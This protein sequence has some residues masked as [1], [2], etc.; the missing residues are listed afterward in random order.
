MKR[1]TFSVVAACLGLALVLALLG[2]GPA[3][4]QSATARIEGVVTDES[5]AAVPGA[6]V[7]ATSLGTNVAKAVKTD[8]KGGYV[9]TPL[10]V[11]AYQVV[12]QM[13]GF[14]RATANVTLTVSQV[15]RIDLKLPLGAVSE[16]IE[17]TGATPIMEQSTS[18]MGTMIDSR[19]VENLPLN[20]RNFTQLATLAPGVNRGTPGSIA[21]GEQG[22]TESFRYGEVGGAALS[23]NGVREQGN[24][25]LLD[26]VDNNETLVNSIVF[27]PPV[28]A[29][30]EFRVITSNA[31]AEFG[32]SGGGII[33]AILKSGSNAFHGSLYEFNRSRG[34]AAT[35]K[36]AAPDPNDPSKKLKPDFKRNQFGATLGGPMI[37]DRAFFFASYSGL[38]STIPVEVGG[39]VTVPTAKMRRGDFSELL[40]PAFTGL[41]RA[42]IVND[43][44]TGQPFAGNVIPQ[45]RLN[46]V[47]VHYL[48][49]FP[50]PD[51]TD[52][53]QYNY[54]THRERKSDFDD[55][56]VRLDYIFGAK[57]TAF[58]RGSYADDHRFD[59]GRIPGYHA[60]FGSGTAQA[61]GQGGVVG[62]THMFSGSL[63]NELRA[64]YNHFEYAFLPVGYGT[65]QN[66]ALGIPGPGGITSANGI[67]LIGGGNGQWIEYL[68]DYGQYVVRQNTLQISDS[69]TWIRGA[70]NFKIGGT[71]MVRNL[72]FERTQIGKGFYF[73]SDATTPSAG[74]TGY[75]VAEMLI[76][77]TQFTATGV[78]GYV[79]RTT[80][81]WEN[82]AFIQDDW[83]VSRK[84]TLN[85]GLRW[86]VFTP[87]YET[88]NKLAN[89]IPT[90]DAQ[91]NVVGGS[92]A[93][94][95]QNGVSRS[96]V[97]TDW[98][99]LG[100]R[101]GLAYQVSDKT[102]VRASWGL[103][104]SLDRGGVDNQ[105]IENPPFVRTQYRFGGAGANVRLSDPIPLPDAVDPSNPVLADGSGVVYLPK[106]T[107][108]SQLHQF[109]LAVQRELSRSTAVT[110]A[111]VGTRG[112]NLTAV[113]STAGFSGAIQGR[114]TTVANIATSKY[115][116]LQIQIRRSH[117]HGFSYLASYT[118]G[119]AKND[120]P[121]PFP[122]SGSS[123]RSTPTDARNLGLD[124]G[125]ADYDVR[126]RFTLAATYDLPFFKSSRAFG[127]WS[128]NTIVAL[129]TGNYFSVYA[130]DVRAN[131]TGD[132]NAGPRTEQQW[133][134]TQAFS[135]PAS[136]T[137][138]NSKRN[139]VLG[140]P[141]KTVD[142]SVFK[143]FRLKSRYGLEMRF[144]CFNAFNT[145]QYAF[146]GQ[147]VGDANFGK[148][149]QAKLNSERQVQLAARLTF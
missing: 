142:L 58:F 95:G 147:F 41:G 31:P 84:L 108:T 30:Q 79:P 141:T 88:Q 77:A 109:N 43:P 5:G 103:F 7:T 47:A 71:L 87:Y 3:W 27:F 94:A 11:G 21:G 50:L 113:T 20:G 144:E 45:G 98:N 124:E 138:G 112:D 85:L 51:L 114:L 15:A 37:K 39:T 18:A 10:P 59:P 104:Y 136:G 83:R 44:A 34:L 22:N 56:D 74:H 106:A 91:G 137:R 64:G 120:S 102:V 35:P 129:Q 49:A 46:P 29:L 128:L 89:F 97:D 54:F 80:R 107:K 61:K 36:F 92:L 38:R 140:P 73:Y 57:T 125:N 16:Q 110:V 26:G 135:A 42:I 17:V 40:S 118:L 86:D 62:V 66:H 117:T 100:P 127:G 12:V 70:H 33:T 123:F 105:L 96:T 13:Q 81:S 60:G 6:A 133:F 52:R 4:S 93:L 143:T 99:N 131:V 55:V 69:L 63:I 139:Q 111:Y 19:Q 76:G 25:Y 9:L 32:R 72:D 146:P 82:S 122:G 68:G 101:L 67:A 126:H 23:V 14:K 115:D 24:T 116:S 8:S 75:E 148:I 28:E 1:R 53:A 145:A 2:A 65:D 132:P 121:G 149:T 48:D 134:D 90:L 130:G 78:P 119:H